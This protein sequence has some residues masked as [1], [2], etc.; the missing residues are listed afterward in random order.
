MGWVGFAQNGQESWVPSGAECV[1]RRGTGPGTP[2]F[3][4]SPEA[5]RT[6]LAKFDFDH[7]LAALDSVLAFA[8]PED[9]MT[10][11]HLIPRLHGADQL[12]VYERTAALVAPPAG[13]T[14]EGI[15]RGDRQMLDQWWD[16]FE[17]GD[18]SMWRIWKG[19]SPFEKR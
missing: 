17:L 3:V 13:V 14:R 11:W 5:F 19:P 8:R 16:E 12:R 15:L 9:A 18:S 10:L 6:A 1:M 2:H 7:D 4:D